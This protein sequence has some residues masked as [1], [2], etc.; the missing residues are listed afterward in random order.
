MPVFRTDSRTG[1]RFRR[2]QH[3]YDFGT[4]QRHHVE[5]ID[6]NLSIVRRLSELGPVVPTVI[7]LQ[8]ILPK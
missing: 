4:P 1:A 2:S 8:E 6:L 5:I 7:R 3:N